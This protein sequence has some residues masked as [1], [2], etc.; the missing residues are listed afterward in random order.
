MQLKLSFDS[1]AVN[2]LFSV[3]SVISASGFNRRLHPPGS[4][5]IDASDANISVADDMAVLFIIQRPKG[6]CV[7]YLLNF[8]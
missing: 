1:S 2:E 5:Y 4:V 3:Y 7:F 6:M 8:P